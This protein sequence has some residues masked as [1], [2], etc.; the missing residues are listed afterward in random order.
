MSSERLLILRPPQALRSADDVL[1]PKTIAGL[2]SAG[3][4][5]RG[6]ELSSQWWAE[7]LWFS[8]LPGRRV[9]F[10]YGPAFLGL[11][12]HRLTMGDASAVWICGSASPL[13]EN[14]WFERAILAQKKPYIFHLLDDWFSI[15]KM[16]KGAE[17]RVAIASLIVVPTEPLKERVLDLFPGAPVL[18]LEEPIDVA[19]VRPLEKFPPSDLPFFVWSG[20]VASLADLKEYAT[21]LEKVYAKHPFKLRIISG[22]NR[23]DLKA[24]FPWEWFPYNPQREAELLS[25]ATA[26]L[27]P[28]EDN[29]YA[30]CKGGY[31]VKTYLSAG[32]PPVASPVGHHQRMIRSGVNGIL[33][34]TEE[35]WISALSQLLA[36][37]AAAQE[38]GRVA[39]ADAVAQYCHDA[40]MPVWAES[41]R[42]AL[43]LR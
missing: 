11:C 42:A 29:A 16:R 13:N 22:Q 8:R 41:L 24:S 14:C 3:L 27:A 26:G 15:P 33:A 4:L 37:P 30:R 32:V 34:T 9:L 6:D 21:I 5:S 28:L 36:D 19:R 23:P 20:H 25:G 18:F 7:K 2:T 35:E 31:K 12:K 17:A 38:M 43:G 40:L 39:R 1:G 10:E